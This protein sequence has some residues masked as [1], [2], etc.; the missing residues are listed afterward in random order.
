[1]KAEPALPHFS[2][3][4]GALPEN[5][6]VAAALSF[7]E[8][9]TSAECDAIVCGAGE[10][11]RYRTSQLHSHEGYRTARTLWLAPGEETRLLAERLSYVIA[12]VNRRYQFDIVGFRDYFLLAQYAVGDG[13]DWHLDASDAESSTRKLS[14]SV[15]LTDPS[16]YEGGRLEFMPQGEIPFSRE[17]GTVIVFPSF[18]CHRVSR[19]TSGA[20]MAA[21]AWAHGPS[22][23]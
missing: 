2:L 17:R 11:L 20:R 23:R 1:V 21:V 3:D 14:L 16:E 19:V 10:R 9:F 8:V 13:F 6:Y 4:R 22:F 5:D 12:Q 7:P 18:L 15:Q